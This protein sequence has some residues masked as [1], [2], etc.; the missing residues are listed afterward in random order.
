[1]Q[2]GSITRF[3]VRQDKPGRGGGD[4]VAND[5]AETS[6]RNPAGK[7]SRPAKVGHQP[8]ASLARPWATVGVKRRQR[9]RGPCD[10]APKARYVAEADTVK[11]VEGN[12]E[13][14]YR[15][16][17]EGPPGSESRARTPGFPRNLGGPDASPKSIPGGDLGDSIPQARARCASR[18]RESEGGA[19]QGYRQAKATE[20]GGKGVGKSEPSIVPGKPGNRPHGTR[21]REGT[22]RAWNRWRERCRRLRASRPSPRD[23]SG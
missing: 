1:M 9:V 17:V 2:A 20:R 16:G 18:P 13:A 7:E 14:L 3:L 22:A 5:I 4:D 19:L 6:G 12:T 11:K 15:P 8:E 10:R 23:S 21:W